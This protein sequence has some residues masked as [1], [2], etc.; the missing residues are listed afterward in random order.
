MAE[1][2]ALP[3]GPQLAA[4]PRLATLP[5]FARALVLPVEYPLR[6][7][8]VGPVAAALSAMSTSQAIYGMPLFGVTAH[9]D[10]FWAIGLLAIPFLAFWG[11][12]WQ[13]CV[14]QRADEPIWP[15]LVR[16]FRRS[17]DYAVAAV[18]ALLGPTLVWMLTFTMAYLIIAGGNL[19]AL[20][21]GWWFWIGSL[22]L[23]LPG[24]WLFA[25]LCFLPAIVA[26][27]G[28]RGA[29][30]RTW[31][32]GRGRDF[33]LVLGFACFVVIGFFLFGATSFIF[34]R[35][36]M[37]VVELTED[38][39]I[40]VATIKYAYLIGQTVAATLLGAWILGFPALIARQLASPTEIDPTAFD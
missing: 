12:A 29:A 37:A 2:A 17:P 33:G 8:L 4:S 22:V 9:P 31:Q 11:C 19:T 32:L 36:I 35:V 26:T 25:R 16:S 14:G 39:Q 7:L 6:L 40:Y 15:W 38:L 5:A 13:R 27:Q 34:F 24:I 1:E 23:A 21:N 18:A 30:E 20:T 3:A 28:W 10:H